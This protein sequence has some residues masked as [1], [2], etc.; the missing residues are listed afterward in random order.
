[1]KSRDEAM[2]GTRARFPGGHEPLSGKT[3]THSRNKKPFRP[4][5]NG[6]F[7]QTMD[8]RNCLSIAYINNFETTI[9][10]HGSAI[11]GRMVFGGEN[12]LLTKAPCWN[13]K[14]EKKIGQF[15]LSLIFLRRNIKNGGYNSTNI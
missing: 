2:S 7:V 12:V 8:R 13:S 5:S 1:M 10:W 14:R 15:L 4:F 11:A 9:T 3:E 6:L